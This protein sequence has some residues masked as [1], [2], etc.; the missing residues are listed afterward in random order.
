MYSR[1]SCYKFQI[2]ITIWVKYSQTQFVMFILLKGFYIACLNKTSYVKTS[3]Q[4]KHYKLCLT[5]LYPY[6]DPIQHKGDVS[7]DSP[8]TELF[9]V[10]D[11]VLNILHATISD[12]VSCNSLKYWTQQELI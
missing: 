2:L 9:S 4:H 11:F 3:Q 8:D 7:S 10:Y 6:Y 5:V 12:T 1:Y